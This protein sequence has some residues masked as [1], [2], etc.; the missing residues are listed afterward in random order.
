MLYDIR[1]HLHYDYAAAL[2]GIFRCK[3]A[4]K[5][6]DPVADAHRAVTEVQDRLRRLAE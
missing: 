6:T 1:L 5:A 2:C 3:K 4:G